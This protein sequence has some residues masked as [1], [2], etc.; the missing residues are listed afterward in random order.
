MLDRL[1]DDIAA[2]ADALGCTAD[3]ERCRTIVGAGTSADA[4]LAVFAANK[5]AGEA[6]A[7]RAV[8]DWLAMATLQ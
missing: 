1:I 2:D 3:I 6:G 7:L 4:Q 5:E 8:S